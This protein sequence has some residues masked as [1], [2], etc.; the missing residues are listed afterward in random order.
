MK[1]ASTYKSQVELLALASVLVLTTACSNISVT[2]NFAVKETAEIAGFVQ[3][4]IS[5]PK[6]YY[7]SG[8]I[9]SKDRTYATVKISLSKDPE[10]TPLQIDLKRHDNAYLAETAIYQEDQFATYLSVGRDKDSKYVAGVRM[11]WNF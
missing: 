4:D 2:P 7:S 6:G 9:K 5:K 1:I 11:R 10:S 8:T 3:E